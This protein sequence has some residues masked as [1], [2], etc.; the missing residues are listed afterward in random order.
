MDAQH[1]LCCEVNF[2]KVPDT[3]DHLLQRP[4]AFSGSIFRYRTDP[5]PASNGPVRLY[6]CVSDTMV[7]GQLLS[8]SPEHL[9]IEM[10]VAVYFCSM[11]EHDVIVISS[12]SLVFVAGKERAEIKE[13]SVGAGQCISQRAVLLICTPATT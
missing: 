1:G 3:A 5:S 7:A 4:D 10:P 9:S 13:E 8:F 11:S 6:S 2:G 12:A